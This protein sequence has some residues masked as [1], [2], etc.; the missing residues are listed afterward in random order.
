MGQPS[1][2]VTFLFTDVEG[3]TRL[4]AEHTEAMEQAMTRHDRLLRHAVDAHGGSVFS[5]AG[6]GL[7]AAF[8]RPVDA[9]SAALDAQRALHAERWEDLPR[10]L[11]VRMGLHT[12]VAYERA[13]DYFGPEVN[14]AARV[15]AAAWGGQTLCTQ[16]MARLADVTTLDLGE[17]R[18]RDI[19]G[20]TSLHQITDA[21]LPADFPPPR[22]LDMPPSTLPAQR[23]T[24]VGR[25]SDIE[26]V[27]HLLLEHR[28]IT[29]TGPGGAGKTRLA[30]EVAGREQPLRP[31]G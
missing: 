12:G 15:M 19:P 24:F 18:L 30:I 14:L 9:A 22:T 21:G 5:T 2:A 16:R 17:H 10:P 27:R 23:S 29:L 7:G 20:T 11:R 4:W 1:G 3:S 25:H 26:A 13:G 6:D 28:V 31:G 8:S